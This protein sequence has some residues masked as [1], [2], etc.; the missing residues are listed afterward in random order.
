MKP[1]ASKAAGRGGRRQEREPVKSMVKWLP[2]LPAGY[3]SKKYM[4]IRIRAAGLA[5]PP[6]F[7]GQIR[8]GMRRKKLL[9]PGRL[10]NRGIWCSWTAPGLIS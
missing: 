8:V 4:T 1:V 2:M 9:E 10:G 7:G 6:V 3:A 5:Q